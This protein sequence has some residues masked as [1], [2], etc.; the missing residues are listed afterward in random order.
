MIRKYSHISVRIPAGM[1]DLFL[2]KVSELTASRWRRDSA[3]EDS[4]GGL[5]A[6][7]GVRYVF[8]CRTDGPRTDIV[9]LYHQDELT[10]NNIF[11]TGRGISY[12]EHG[13]V[14]QDFWDSGMGAACAALGLAGK[15]TPPRSMK[16]EELLPP[17]AAKA[18][19]EFALCANKSTGAA[20]PDDMQ[21][22]CLFLSLLHR[23]HAEFNAS[24]LEQYLRAKKFPIEVVENLILQWEFSQSLLEIYDAVLEVEAQPTVQ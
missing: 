11:T 1:L 18:L 6:V 3:A 7:M 20:H 8:Y 15:H 19:Y 10:L 5:P 12:A 22:W 24:H 13:R 2:A 17:G 4:V 23:S 21:R 16:P 9:F 14:S